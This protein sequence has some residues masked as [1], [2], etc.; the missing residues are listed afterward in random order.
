MKH[1]NKTPR[2]IKKCRTTVNITESVLNWARLHEINLSAVLE[3]AIR[4]RMMKL[5]ADNDS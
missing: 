5:A 2:G 1:Y 3:N 4:Q